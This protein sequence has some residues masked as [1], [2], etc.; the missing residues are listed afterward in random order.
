MQPVGDPRAGD[1]HEAFAAVRA[2]L[3]VLLRGPVPGRGAGRRDRRGHPVAAGSARRSSTTRP[4]T[5]RPTGC[6]STPRSTSGRCGRST[7]R[8]SSGSSRPASRGRSC[9]PTTRSTGC[10][11]RRTR[12]C[13][14]TV[15][16]EEFGFEGLV[17]SDW[18]AVYHRVPGARRRGSTW[19]CRRTCRAARTRSSPPS[20]PASWTSRSSTP[21]SAPS[22]SWSDKGM[23]V[24]E[25][26]EDFDADAHHRLARAAAAESVVLLK[27]DGRRFCRS[28]PESRIAVIGEFARTPRFQGAGSS[29]VTP[30][31]VEN[32]LDELTA[33]FARGDVRRRLRDRRH[34]RRR[35]P[36]RAEAVERRGGRRHRGHADR[37]ARRRRVGGLRP[38]PHEPARQPDRRPARGRGGQPERRR[39]AG[40]RLDGRAGRGR[41]ARPRRSSRR[42][43][44]G[45]PPAGAIAD[46]L[47]GAV[48]PSGRLAETVPH[49]LEDNSS[50]LNF[51]GDSRVVRYGE[52]LFIGYRGYDAI[53]HR[54]RVPVR[55]RP[56]VHD[57]RAVRPGRR[58]LRIRR[59]RATSTAEVDGHRHQHRTGGRGGGRAGLRPRRRAPRSPGRCASSR[60]SPR[61]P[62]SPGSPGRSR[63]LWTSARSRS[64]PSCS[65]GGW[66]R[67]ASS[68]SRSG[69]TPATCR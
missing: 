46:V 22:W 25:L 16:R 15:L 29:Q 27:N 50:Y 6:G 68:R 59:R 58:D 52:G 12:G 3:R 53:A 4:T 36:L 65:A 30:T 7:S 39:R 51:P 44:A 31:R 38:H 10:R 14:P 63:S 20:A 54:R 61:S 67:P 1:Q 64:G 42:G 33:A 34:E 18:G 62:W 9:A 55:V 41:P 69:R 40:Q 13:S 11:R 24:L 21:G 17:V 48:N 8:R 37:A 49:R 2:Q 35:R 5:R 26:D 45:R 57:V 28:A 60:A 66:S 47:S 43:S 32:A 23:D 19:R 56:V